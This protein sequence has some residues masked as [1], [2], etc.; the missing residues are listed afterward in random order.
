[1]LL[2]GSHEL[3]SRFYPGIA[4]TT[5]QQMVLAEQN[6]MRLYQLRANPALIDEPR[7]TADFLW[8]LAGDEVKR[9]G[10]LSSSPS[11]Y[12][13]RG[14][15]QF[16]AEDSRKAFL[17]DHRE[18]ILART[19]ALPTELVELVTMKF[20][21]YDERAG[22]LNIILS[23]LSVP[24][25][26]HGRIGK[27]VPFTS[28]TTWAMSPEEA[29]KL[30]E[31]VKLQRAQYETG[32]R[33]IVAVR[34]KVVG[35]VV[36]ERGAILDTVASEFSFYDIGL[37]RKI[38]DL[39]FPPGAITVNNPR[40]DA[41]AAG[42]VPEFDAI[43]PKLWAVAADPRRLD[44]RSFLIE[45]FQIRR[46][47]ERQKW[48]E[49]PSEPISFPRFIGVAMLAADPGLPPTEAHLQ[50]TRTWLKAHA[51][52]LSKRVVLGQMAVRAKGNQQVADLT[53][54]MGLY[55]GSV[56]SSPEWRISHNTAPW[57]PEAVRAASAALPNSAGIFP[58]SVG[59]KTRALV[60]LHPN[61]A[62]A[63]V[64]LPVSAENIFG[65]GALE[66]EIL[67]AKTLTAG[68]GTVLLFD[69]RPTSLTLSRAGKEHRVRFNERAAAQAAA[70]ALSGVPASPT[71]LASHYEVANV[72]LG[73]PLAKAEAAARAFIGKPV[74]RVEG[75]TRF[76][77][78]AD[79][80]VLREPGS[81][82]HSSPGELVVLFFDKTL[83]ERPVIAIGRK[84]KIASSRTFDEVSQELVAQLSAKYGKPVAVARNP[85]DYTYW[86]RSPVAAK[87]LVGLGDSKSSCSAYHF[88]NFPSVDAPTP[89]N[90]TGMGRFGYDIQGI[91]DCGEVAS[92]ELFR[93]KLLLQFV[94]DTTLY[95][96]KLTREAAL[97]P[98]AA[99]EQKVKF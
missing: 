88:N 4:R 62:W 68:G 91:K 22:V 17:R 46:V 1:M 50:A 52:N 48:K 99:P 87:E 6:L 47:H 12:N 11:Q 24:Q 5:M 54:S 31:Q 63:G 9:Y 16:E 79:A 80:I 55:L 59:E 23:F 75:V 97:K 58:L 56:R 43:Y 2:N 15:N 29:R 33:G 72:T 81:K 77:P 53:S 34:Y 96:P 78:L 98:P 64:E 18:A 83:P 27:P 65:P 84:T 41:P 19:K 25:N 92:I 51:A 94:T 39:P 85:N 28:P 36:T 95:G 76:A 38:A 66:L 82:G 26:T 69:V 49:Q 86:T 90:Y 44:D 60:A 70:P 67:D 21:R 13:W 7:R 57:V 45:A 74:E 40:I 14:S 93:D 89:L 10:G 71:A 37:Q 20:D 42:V 30:F 32:T 3:Y 61:M 35:D 8:L 73:M